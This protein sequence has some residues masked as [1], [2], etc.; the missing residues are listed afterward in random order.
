MQNEVIC[1]LNDR[2]AIKSRI[3]GCL[4]GLAVGNVLGLSAESMSRDESRRVLGISGELRRLPVE[5]TGRP[6]DG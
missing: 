2:S 3:R 1:M 4:W 5:E 6:W